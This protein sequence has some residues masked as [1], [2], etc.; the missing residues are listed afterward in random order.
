VPDRLRIGQ[1][2]SRLLSHFEAELMLQAR[3]RLGTDHGIRVPHSKVLGTIDAGGTRLTELARRA[4]VVQS[5]M[6]ELVDDLEAKGYVERVPD[7]T[8]GRAK[9]ICLTDRGWE[10]VRTARAVVEDLERDYGRRVGQ[11]RFEETCLVLQEL[12]DSLAGESPR[13]GSE[14]TDREP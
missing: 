3:A 12:L 1:L 11:R 5:A 7:P 8:D 4:G 13:V 10:G 6:A 9:L 2:F 14:S